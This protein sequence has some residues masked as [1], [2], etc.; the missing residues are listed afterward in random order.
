LNVSRF[1]PR[2]EFGKATLWRAER[3]ISE[4]LLRTL[5]ETDL[6]LVATFATTNQMAFG[7]A[8]LEAGAFIESSTD[9]ERRNDQSYVVQAVDH[10]GLS[11]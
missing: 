3:Y 10:V 1:E 9:F 6:V 4:A 7:H 2:A 8:G 11:G 5:N